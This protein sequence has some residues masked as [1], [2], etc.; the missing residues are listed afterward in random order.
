[1]L[2]KRPLEN[3]RIEIKNIAKRR[4]LLLADHFLEKI[5]DIYINS[6]VRQQIIVI[7]QM[8]DSV[9]KERKLKHYIL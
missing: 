2:T 3:F 7:G 5:L 6:N 4:E 9:N 1:M 8:D